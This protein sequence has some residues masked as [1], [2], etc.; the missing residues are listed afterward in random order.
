MDARSDEATERRSVGRRNCISALI[1]A[2]A[3]TAFISGLGPREVRPTRQ[4]PEKVFSR[5]EVVVGSVRF[6][7]ATRDSDFQQRNERV[8]S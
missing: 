2:S 4:S 1:I 3:R 6:G 7:S 5:L 8:L